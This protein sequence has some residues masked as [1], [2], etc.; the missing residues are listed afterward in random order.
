MR[1]VKPA[2][3]VT[4]IRAR[5]A[6]MLSQ[7]SGR[8]RPLC[9]GSV[10]VGWLDDT[11]AEM[12]AAF[13]DVFEVDAARISFG[14]GFADCR[15][16]T[17]AMDDVTRALSAAGRLSAWRDER[18]A[19]A[20]VFGGESLF[21]IERAAARFFGIKTYAVHINGL[22][23]G[24]GVAG[25]SGVG[26]WIARRSALKGIDPGMLDNVVGGGIAAGSTVRST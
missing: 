11:R 18:Y 24:T 12:L 20:D 25:T 8:Y 22:V 23:A 5:L 4:A 10:I 7:P 14:P 6:P 13:R 17:A 3:I 21:L 9:A 15:T 16:R 1:G 19:V 2:R 26:M